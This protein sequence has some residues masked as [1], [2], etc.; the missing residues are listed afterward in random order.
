[1]RFEI[2]DR[3]VYR[4]NYLSAP[5]GRITDIKDGLVS[6]YY[7]WDKTYSYQPDELEICFTAY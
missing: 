2:G 6:I 5:I 1:M 3:V 4:P 7:P